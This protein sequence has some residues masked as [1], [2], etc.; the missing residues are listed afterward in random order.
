MDSSTNTGDPAS[1]GLPTNVVIPKLKTVEEMLFLH[2]DLSNVDGY[3]KLMPVLE[4]RG[5]TKKIPTSVLGASK[6]LRK[7]LLAMQGFRRSSDAV[8]TKVKGE[9][10]NMTRAMQN[11]AK[12][13]VEHLNMLK[14]QL[15]AG[16]M[17][18]ESV[19]PD[20][21]TELQ[22]V[23]CQQP[24]RAAAKS[25]NN[26]Y[27]NAQDMWIHGFMEK[28]RAASENQANNL[29]TSPPL[30]SRSTDNAGNPKAR[31]V[32][33]EEEE[34][35]VKEVPANSKHTGLFSDTIERNKVGDNFDKKG[36]TTSSA[37]KEG[38]FATTS[39]QQA[40]SASQTAL[41]KAFKAV[42]TAADAMHRPTC[43]EGQPRSAIIAIH[44]TEL[45]DKAPVSGCNKKDE[46]QSVVR[47][48]PLVTMCGEENDE[49]LM[50]V[51]WQLMEALKHKVPKKVERAAL[52]RINPSG[53]N[54]V[55]TTVA[56]FYN[57]KDKVAGAQ[58]KKKARS[59]AEVRDEQHNKLQ[60]SIVIC[61]NH[62]RVCATCD[63]VVNYIFL[64]SAVPYQLQQVPQNIL[65]LRSPNST[66]SAVPP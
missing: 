61:W 7:L 19:A 45:C 41:K 25:D 24:A 32:T 9:W 29:L 15:L 38:A 59:G 2:V 5:Q 58:P 40:D 62:C 49:E 55:S 4:G 14:N 20:P 52:S 36:K 28:Q 22:P 1:K 63:K 23:Q 37:H 66:V 11:A 16:S 43:T 27:N 53:D 33:P 50:W 6:N 65:T 12:A 21:Q 42:A 39:Y 10:G 35:D 54:R 60:Q 26:K 57:E 3:I 34:D 31:A 8:Q 48:R 44:V 17:D 51:M 64:L 47:K 56:S 13:N 18:W 30:Q 46:A